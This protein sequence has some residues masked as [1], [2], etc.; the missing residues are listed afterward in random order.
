MMFCTDC[1]GSEVDL[2]TPGGVPEKDGGGVSSLSALPY[3]SQGRA[4]AGYNLFMSEA[5]IL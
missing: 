4:S 3:D 2:Q 1:L 5:L